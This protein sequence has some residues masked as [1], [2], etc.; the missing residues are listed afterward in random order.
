MAPFLCN[1]NETGKGFAMLEFL[2]RYQNRILGSISGF[3]RIRFRGTIRWLAN[4]FGVRSFAAVHHILYKDFTRWAQGVTKQVRACCAKRAEDLGIPTVYLRCAGINK[5]EMARSIAKERGVD[6]G[7]ICMFSTVEMCRAPT[8]RGNP[9]TQK[10]ELHMEPRKCVW[11]YHYWNHPEFGFGH[12]RLQT[13]LPL[14]VTACVNGRHWFERQLLAAGVDY[15]KDGN[16][17][18]YIEN[19]EYAQ[20]LFAAQLQTNWPQMLDGLLRHSCPNIDHILPISPHY[21]WSADATE[22]ATDILFKST[23]DLDQL[24]PAIVLH[25]MLTAQSPVVTRF[26]GRKDGRGRMPA[27]VASDCRQRYEGV[28]LKHCVNRNSIKIYNKAGSVLRVETT[29]NST[30][31]FKVYR[32]PNDDESRPASYQKMRKGV[33][34]LH[35]RAQVS[36]AANARYL[37]HLAAANIDQT[38]RQTVGDICSHAIRKRRRY[39]GLN[40]LEDED[41]KMLQFLARGENTINGFRNRNLRDFLYGQF[42]NDAKQRRRASA[43]TTRRLA[44]LRA[45]RLINKV[46]KTN[47]Y[48]LSAKGQKLANAVVAASNVDTKQLMELAA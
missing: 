1:H 37:D 8:I 34:D 44:L 7:D 22:W 36:Q 33:S 9:S 10:L 46:A 39:R 19:L 47:R 4:D 38:L 14:S 25:G 2:K 32:R 16:C 42:D 20:E 13:W 28:R 18:P 41:F 17:F 12:T 43:R 30:R 3:D 23:H 5:E 15:R 11:I 40:P 31:D 48:V 29:I 26:L 27:E 35:R 45:H 6:V 24:F 21:Y